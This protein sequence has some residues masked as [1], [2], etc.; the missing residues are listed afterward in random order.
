M[1]LFLDNFRFSNNFEIIL[2]VLR[3]NLNTKI[4]SKLF[5]TNFILRATKALES[6]CEGKQQVYEPPPGV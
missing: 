5:Q 4:I 1:K 3:V 2:D 6:S